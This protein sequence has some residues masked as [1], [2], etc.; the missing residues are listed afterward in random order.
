[1]DT[2]V[3]ELLTRLLALPPAERSAIAATLLESLG[4]RDKPDPAA[5]RKSEALPT[6]VTHCA[7]LL[8]PV[9]AVRSRR[10]FAGQGLYIDDVFVAI[11]V[12][13]TLY[14]K[15]DEETQPRF[16]AAGGRQ[17]EYT[18]KGESHTA[19]Y[20]SAPTDAMKSPE[21]MRPWAQL[22]LLAAKRAGTRKRPRR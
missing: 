4:K 22:A 8:A 2:R 12:G 6:F 18:R 20:W 11:V 7:E 16:K 3:D 5:R 1:M 19:A 10:M 15:V 21:L 13:D 14:L 17:F 9:G